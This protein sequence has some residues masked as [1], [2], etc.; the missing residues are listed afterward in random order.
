M[1]W[2][3]NIPFVSM[4]WVKE[5]FPIFCGILNKFTIVGMRLADIFLLDLELIKLTAAKHLEANP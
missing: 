3:Y 1:V 5:K 2:I 4:R